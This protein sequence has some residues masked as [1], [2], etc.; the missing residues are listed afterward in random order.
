MTTINKK[1]SYLLSFC[2]GCYFESCSFITYA[3]CS[4][5]A[6]NSWKT[7]KTFFFFQYPLLLLSLYVAVTP[8]H[9]IYLMCSTPKITIFGI[10]ADVPSG[11]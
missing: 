8:H 5:L 2:F 3:V 10:H 7:I 1:S 11:T 9:R 6:Q 4:P